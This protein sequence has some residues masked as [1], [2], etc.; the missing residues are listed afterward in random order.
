MITIA[1]HKIVPT[2]FPDK[3][4]QVWKLPEEVFTSPYDI[5]WTFESEAEIMHLAQLKAL[6][7]KRDFSANK[8]LHIDCLPYARQDK[9]VS[10][11]STFALHS[12]AKL[13]NA[14]EFDS[15]RIMDPHS[16]VATKLI[17][18]AHAIYPFKQVIDIIDALGVTTVIYPDH[19]AEFKYT[20]FYG[21][22]DN[23]YPKVLIGEKE[24]DQ[25][26]GHILK[27][28]LSGDP[29]GQICLMVDDLCDGGAT[30]ILLAKEL[31]SKGAKEVHLFVSHGIFSRGLGVLF[32]AGIKRV[33]VK[34]GEMHVLKN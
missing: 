15:I 24:R 23:R 34:D 8:T 21:G 5:F 12:F 26:T 27:Y 29:S 11:T 7:D 1:G 2:I 20:S 31:L 16:N 33:F 6:L 13:L 28:E 9:D 19:G 10:N 25:Q 4:S 3:T 30:F 22:F 32:D 17:F 14:M 18:N